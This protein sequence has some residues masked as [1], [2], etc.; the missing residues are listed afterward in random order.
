MWVQFSG[1]ETRKSPHMLVIGSANPCTFGFPRTNR[2]H[3]RG[4]RRNTP[5]MV[6]PC[7]SRLEPSKGWWMVGGKPWPTI[8]GGLDIKLC[9]DQYY[10]YLSALW[11]NPPPVHS[12]LVHVYNMFFR[13]IGFQPSKIIQ[14]A[15]EDFLP[16]YGMTWNDME[17]LVWF[18]VVPPNFYGS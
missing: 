8:V 5:I 15:V 12:W 9:Q 10:W 13:F 17:Y 1:M 11:R 4:S 16:Q 18:N 14:G 3:S 6:T 2:Q 7:P